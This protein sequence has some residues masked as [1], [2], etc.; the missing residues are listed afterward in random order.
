MMAPPWMLLFSNLLCDCGLAQQQNH[1]NCGVVFR[2]A[3]KM[4]TAMER[5]AHTFK[6]TIPE[7][8]ANPLSVNQSDHDDHHNCMLHA[9][10]TDVSNSQSEQIKSYITSSLKQATGNY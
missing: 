5:W 7:Y 6:I 4:A 10:F 9:M 3:G 1:L 2:R 8:K